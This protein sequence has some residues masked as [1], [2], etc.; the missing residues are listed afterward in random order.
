MPSLCVSITMTVGAVM[1]F[2]TIKS[3][4][5]IIHIYCINIV[6]LFLDSSLFLFRILPA[7]HTLNLYNNIALTRA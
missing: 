5:I 2:W 7:N 3:Y 1:A 6:L 4:H